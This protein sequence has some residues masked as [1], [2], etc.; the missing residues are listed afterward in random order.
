M[1]FTFK[2]NTETRILELFTVIYLE[3]RQKSLAKNETGK[4]ARVPPARTARMG[5]PHDPGLS[6]ALSKS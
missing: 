1:T 2:T 6:E 4:F 3:V 5:G